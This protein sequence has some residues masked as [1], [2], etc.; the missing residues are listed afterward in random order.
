MERSPPLAQLS[1]SGMATHS[2]DLQGLFSNL[3]SSNFCPQKGNILPVP[4]KWN[5]SHWCLLKTSLNIFLTIQCLWSL[6]SLQ[7]TGLAI[8]SKMSLLF[9][10]FQIIPTSML[11]DFLVQAS[12]LLIDLGTPSCPGIF[13]RTEL[14][15]TVF[16]SCLFA[17]LSIE[18]FSHGFELMYFWYD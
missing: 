7:V 10:Y 11:W 5:S 4:R 2:P 15:Y 9:V 18:L 16:Y 17:L 1:I 6:P 8:S 12:P 14:H 3:L 13:L